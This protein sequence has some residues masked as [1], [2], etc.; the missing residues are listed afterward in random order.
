[1]FLN[2]VPKVLVAAFCACVI[3]STLPVGYLLNEL[4]TLRWNVQQL[5]NMTSDSTRIRAVS[6]K[7]DGLI[8]NLEIVTLDP[9]PA[10]RAEFIGATDLS[11]KLLTHSIRQLWDSEANLF[12]VPQFVELHELSDKLSADWN[13]I[14]PKVIN[15]L[16]QADKVAFFV[17]YSN[18]IKLSRATLEELQDYS[19]KI[20][21]TKVHSSYER[22]EFSSLL[23]A[24]GLMIWIAITM[25]SSGVRK[26][27]MHF[28]ATVFGEW[29][30]TVMECSTARR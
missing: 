16:S 9:Q 28:V 1:M 7:I 11:L 21:D 18:D 10:K 23:V 20:S 13:A 26:Y 2:R 22:L 24:T 4:S 30:A 12:K 29:T 3:L 5:Q 27:P 25:G 8:T 6:N 15:G 19:K 17:K 14:K